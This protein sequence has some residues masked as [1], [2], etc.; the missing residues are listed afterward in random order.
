[1]GGLDRVRIVCFG[2]EVFPTI[3]R[4]NGG[5]QADISPNC[6]RE[7]WGQRDS[8]NSVGYIRKVYLLVVSYICVVTGHSR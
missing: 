6:F 7:I 5:G 3:V 2:V 4:R 8:P 1:M